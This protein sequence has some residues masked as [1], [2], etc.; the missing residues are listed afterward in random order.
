MDLNNLEGHIRAYFR[1]RDVSLTQSAV[2]ILLNPQYLI[3]EVMNRM[4]PNNVI[5]NVNIV[6]N[7]VIAMHNQQLEKE[8]RVRKKWWRTSYI[9]KKS[10]KKH[11]ITDA[12]VKSVLGQHFGKLPPYSSSL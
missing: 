6:L 11:H 3:L 1:K 5:D 10:L 12:D 7:D 2:Q 9:L 4:E 8:F